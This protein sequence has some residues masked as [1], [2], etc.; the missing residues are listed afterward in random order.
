MTVTAHARAQ[1][2][3]S[4][5]IVADLQPDDLDPWRRRDAYPAPYTC[6]RNG[7]WPHEEGCQAALWARACSDC[8]DTFARFLALLRTDGAMAP[9]EASVSTR[10]LHYIWEKPGY[11]R[12]DHWSGTLFGADGCAVDRWE[13]LCAPLRPEDAIWHRIPHGE[14]DAFVAALDGLRWEGMGRKGERPDQAP[15]GK[16]AERER[17]VKA[18]VKLRDRWKDWK[19]TPWR[20]VANARA[21]SYRAWE[22]EWPA[23]RAGE[24]LTFVKPAPARLFSQFERRQLV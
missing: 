20:V 3:A 4:L 16:G 7:R 17:I 21:E 11:R 23:R 19:G 8:G 18:A 10:V 15:I 6:D 13:W 9:W 1:V 22:R 14:E 5:P 12:P 24:P 2:N